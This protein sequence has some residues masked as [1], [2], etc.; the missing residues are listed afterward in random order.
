MDEAELK[1]LWA[2]DAVPARDLSFEL[3]VMARIEQRRFRRALTVNVALAAAGALLLA[4]L[5]PAL[6]TVWQ[7]NFAATIS[8][9]M[10]AAMLS[11]AMLLL[12]RWIVQRS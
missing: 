8:N 3:A 7:N 5:M 4:L 2:R 12:Q 1:A 6:Q 10:I 9:W 11:I